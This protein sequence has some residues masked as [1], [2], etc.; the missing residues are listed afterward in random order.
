MTPS[1]R[2]P[3]RLDTLLGRRP[4]RAATI[5]LA[6]LARYD[7]LALH[8][9]RGMGDRPGDRRFPGHRDPAG[10]EIEAYVPYTPGDDLR[11]LDWNAVGRLDALLIRRFT[12]ERAVCVDLLLD[13]SASMSVPSRDDKLGAARELA[14]ALA[15]VALGTNDAVRVSLLADD[16]TTHTSPVHRHRASIARVAELLATTVTGG[17]LSLGD[18]LAAHARRHPRPGAAIV[19]SDLMAEPTEIE[20]GVQALRARRYDVTLLHVLGRSEIAPGRASGHAVLADVESGAQHP[21]RLTADA[22]ARYQSALAEHLA[23][24]DALATRND[25]RYARLVTD[26]G[27]DAF[28]TGAL[29]RLGILRRR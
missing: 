9:R 26:E 27:V 2:Q 11:H 14:T 8:V 21:I 23:A 5:D 1:G 7:G 13:A 29:P 20:R 3:G 28:V 19:V 24:L 12:A 18:A 6:A 4:A 10:V 22:I 25:V 15:F 17:A 16:A